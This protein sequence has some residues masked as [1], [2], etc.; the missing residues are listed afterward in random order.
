ML[1][2]P[3]MTSVG[4]EGLTNLQTAAIILDVM[5]NLFQDI[6]AELPKELIEV[7]ASSDCVRIE[8]IVSRG[9]ASEPGFWFDQNTTEFVVLLAGQARLQFQTRA[10]PVTL[11][12]GDYLTIAPGEKHRVTWTHPEAET[13]WLAVHY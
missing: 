7:I 2:L 12:P 11:L 1:S 8:R 6:P 10:E 4:E 3:Q 13:V 5:D 9:Q